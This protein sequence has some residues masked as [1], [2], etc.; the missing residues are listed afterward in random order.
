MNKRELDTT[1]STATTATA[2]DNDDGDIGRPTKIAKLAKVSDRVNVVASHYSERRETSRSE[3]AQSSTINLKNYNNWLKSVLINQYCRK[4]DFVLD[5]CSGKGGDLSKYVKMQIGAL[6]CAG[7]FVVV[8]WLLF[9]KKK[10][11]K[12]KKKTTH[13][14]GREICRTV[15]ATLQ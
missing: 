3:R 8:F 7:M 2:N 5:I 11:K 15:V 6:I 10:K 14:C 9:A 12:K 13:R 4:G 1:A